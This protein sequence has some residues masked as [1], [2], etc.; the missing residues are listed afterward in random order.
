MINASAIVS[1]VFES[2]MFKKPNKYE[3]LNIHGLEEGELNARCYICEVNG[4]NLQSTCGMCISP[5]NG[6]GNNRDVSKAIEYVAARLVSC[7]T[8]CVYIYK[9]NIGTRHASSNIWNLLG[10]SE[11]LRLESIET[12]AKLMRKFI[13]K[14]S[15]MIISNQFTKD[16]IMYLITGDEQY[17]EASTKSQ[18]NQ[19]QN[20]SS[21]THPS[22]SGLPLTACVDKISTWYSRLSQWLLLLIQ[23][24]P[25]LSGRYLKASSNA[26]LH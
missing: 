24:L 15:F 19:H 16:L 4:S 14:S 12:S 1:S 10:K 17:R 20:S 25:I 26:S 18:P 8:D 13:I 22:N 6:D 5:R 9:T 23:K 7:S 11:I 21:V 3:A 2:P